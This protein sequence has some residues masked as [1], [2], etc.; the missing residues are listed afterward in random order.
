M[1]KEKQSYFIT[2]TD[3]EIGKTF[4]TSTL[5]YLF[6]QQGEKVVGMKP[7]A[8]G[9]TM[10]NGV[11]VNEDVAALQV[12][13]KV[14]VAVDLMAPYVFPL[15]VAPHIAAKEAGRTIDIA[16]CILCYRNLHTM[17]DRVL[18]E[19]VGGFRVPLTDQEDTT[20]LA[21]GLG[22]PIIMVVGMRLG[23]ISMALL[24]IEAILARG[25]TLA[26]WVANIIDPHM[27]HIEDNI[28]ALEKRIPAPLLGK[29]PYLAQALPEGAVSYLDI[30]LL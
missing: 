5:L 16:Q 27:V 22:L 19:G 21:L 25:L 30:S 23:C 28:A 8:A 1:K 2:G 26:G 14:K 13:S 3:T 9:A 4:V 17:A 7:I 6:A 10:E 29:S 18:V 12:A 24:T 20:D 11:W 15:A